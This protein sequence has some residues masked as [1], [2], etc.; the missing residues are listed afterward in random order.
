MAQH[1][2]G[3]LSFTAPPRSSGRLRHSLSA[4]SRALFDEWRTAGLEVTVEF[5][6]EGSSSEIAKPAPRTARV[7]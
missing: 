3:R 7:A 1:M 4:L 6:D 2:V 5:G